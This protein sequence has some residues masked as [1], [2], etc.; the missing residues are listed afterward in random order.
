MRWEWWAYAGITLVCLAIAFIADRYSQKKPAKPGRHANTGEIPT[1]TH[2]LADDWSFKTAEQPVVKLT[3][4]PPVPPF[5]PPTVEME[6]IDP[7]DYPDWISEMLKEDL[8]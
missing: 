2:R 3:E 8:R 5:A 4:K 7:A 1:V 6:A